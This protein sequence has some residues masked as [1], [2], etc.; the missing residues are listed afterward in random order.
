ME[1]DQCGLRPLSFDVSLSEATDAHSL[2]AIGTVMA[3]LQGACELLK[4][5]P[6]LALELHVDLLLQ[7][8][9]SAREVW[10]F[11][12]D[13]NMFSNRRVTMLSRPNWDEIMTVN[14]FADLPQNGVVNIFVG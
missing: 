13:Q 11:L 12:S 9:S 6:K 14:S 5:G 4:H 3:V 10:Q 2:Q 8:G 1:S 7:A